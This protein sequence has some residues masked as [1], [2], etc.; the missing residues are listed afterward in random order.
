MAEEDKAII[1]FPLEFPIKVMGEASEEFTASIVKTIQTIW[2][3]FDH[4]HVELRSSSG[5]RYISLTCTVWATS[6][7]QLDDIYRAITAHPDVK[8]VL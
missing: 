7:E 1:E 5:G 2:P 6:R 3:E 4:Q 8:Y